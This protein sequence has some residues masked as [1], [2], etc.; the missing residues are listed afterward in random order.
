MP[1]TSAISG[2]AAHSLVAAK[3]SALSS[4][5]QQALRLRVVEERPY[6]EVASLLGITEPTARGRAARGLRALTP[7]LTA[8]CSHERNSHE[9]AT[10]CSDRIGCRA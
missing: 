4:G 6:Q 8:V 7:R 5:Q 1:Q 10:A 2:Q 3:L 9:S